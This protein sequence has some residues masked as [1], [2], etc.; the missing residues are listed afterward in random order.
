MHALLLRR[1]GP[2]GDGEH[3]EEGEHLEGVQ[4]VNDLWGVLT[5]VEQQNTRNHP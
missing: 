5:W 4:V 1:V 2:E 3:K